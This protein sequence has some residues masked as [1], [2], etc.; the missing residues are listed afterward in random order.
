MST[1]GTETNESVFTVPHFINGKEHHLEKTFDVVSPATGK[2]AIRCGTSSV[3][4][5][6]AVVKVAAE[7]FKTWR[8][9]TPAQRRDIFLKAAEVMKNRRQEL[10]R[11]MREETG[12]TQAW[13]DFNVECTLEYIKD[14]AGRIS[15]LE[16]SFPT[17]MDPNSSGIVMRE[18]FGVVFAIAP[19]NAP[20][21]LGTRSIAFPIAA[22][23]TAV[24]KGSEASPRTMFAIASVFH[25]AGLPNGVLNMIVNERAAAAAVT[26]AIIANPLV[27][28]INFTGSSGIARIIAK[29]AGEN[30]KP[31]VLELGGKAPAIVWEDANLQLAADQCALGSFLHGGQI[32][33]ST[34]RILVHKAI[35]NEFVDKLKASVEKIFPSGEEALTLINSASVDKNKELVADATRKGASVI[36]GNIEAPEISNT[37]LRPIVVDNVTPEMDIYK[38]ESFGPTVSLIEIDSEEEAIRIANDT[39]YGL[40]SAVFTEDLR[41]GLRFAREIE[42]GAVHIN[43][44]TVHDETVLPHGGTKAS[45]YGRFNG[46]RGLDEW[47]RTKSVTFLN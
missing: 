18:P 33:M 19:W 22:G 13:C 46:A 14:I 2:I 47:T 8:K 35:K 38:T 42:A 25:E 11:Y 24:L 4:D 1:S 10:A 43:G 16:G 44:M 17:L 26:S 5:A 45:G 7:A 39:E 12:S 15:A 21:I 34:E 27:K 20:Y 31:V 9:T 41:R 30:L 29:L 23:N 32:C 6:N 3:A 40:S 36:F 28:K 37:R